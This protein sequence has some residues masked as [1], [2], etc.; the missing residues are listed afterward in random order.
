M[1]ILNDRVALAYTIILL[2]NESYNTN[3]KNPMI[4]TLAKN[5]IKKIKKPTTTTSNK[6][7]NSLMLSLFSIVEDILDDGVKKPIETKHFKQ[8][9]KFLTINFPEIHELLTE[10]FNQLESGKPQEQIKE[11]LGVYYN[12]L[13]EY[14]SN[15]EL[16]KIFNNYFFKLEEVKGQLEDPETFLNAMMA[17]CAPLASKRKGGSLDTLP[18]IHGHV[19]LANPDT[20]K[21]AWDIAKEIDSDE[22]LLVTDLEGW[23]ALFGGGLRRGEIIDLEARTGC[24]K[25]DTMRRIIRGVMKTTTPH[26]FTVGDKVPTILIFSMEDTTDKIVKHLYC[27][28]LEEKT[29]TQ[30]D[31]STVDS[32]EAFKY[33]KEV[34]GA[35]GYHL[36]IVYGKKHTITVKNVAQ[37]IDILENSG[38]EIHLMA[39]DYLQNMRSDDMPG[40]NTAVQIKNCLGSLG[41][42]TKPKKITLLVANQ[43]KK[44]PEVT[45]AVTDNVEFAQY[46]VGKAWC[47]NCTSVTN[48]VD[49]ELVGHIREGDDGNWYHQLAIGKHRYG[50]YTPRDHKYAVYRMGKDEQGG[51]AGFIKGDVDAEHSMV[52]NAT[53]GQYRVHGGGAGDFF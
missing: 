6:D 15:K 43:I 12:T 21:E 42:V 39:L 5:I 50:K 30:I 19:S 27:D 35:K 48:E 37:T 9:L 45:Q 1:K 13:N 29:G 44:A 40:G 20:F 18:F 31:I 7:V 16:K 34:L 41:D 8:Q 22:G 24:G 52:R 26:N 17:E 33:V 46:A 3:A 28:D 32:D 23:N 51:K 47:E 36:E 53:A 4:P 49:M 25:S 38:H 11:T 10:E 2:A 14:Y